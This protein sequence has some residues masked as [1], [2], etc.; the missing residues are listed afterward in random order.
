MVRRS[1]KRVKALPIEPGPSK[2]RQGKDKSEPSSHV[3]GQFPVS[4]K[5]H[6]VEIVGT[7]QKEANEVYLRRF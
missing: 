2:G 6:W 3:D 5:D 7:P 4:G 1:S